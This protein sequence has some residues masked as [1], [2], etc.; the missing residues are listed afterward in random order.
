VSVIARPLDVKKLARPLHIRL[1][2]LQGSRLTGLQQI[3]TLLCL[4]LTRI[5][6]LLGKLITLGE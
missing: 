6:Q 1:G 5:E 3:N 4:L 2:S